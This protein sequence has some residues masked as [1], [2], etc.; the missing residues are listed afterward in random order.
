MFLLNFSVRYSVL[1]SIER[2][3]YHQFVLYLK[4]YRI[5][6]TQ[7]CFA[8]RTKPNKSFTI[9]NYPIEFFAAI[10]RIFKKAKKLFYNLKDEEILLG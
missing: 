5:P 3:I 7:I 2:K 4:G 6:V 10:S 8:V 1:Q 9:S